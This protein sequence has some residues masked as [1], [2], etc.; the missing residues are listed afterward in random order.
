M[1]TCTK[2]K[3]EKDETEFSYSSYSSDRLQSW[4]QECNRK[5]HKKDTIQGF[6]GHLWHCFRMTLVEYELMLESQNEKCAI[7]G[8]LE[9][10]KRGKDKIRRLSVDHDHETGIIRDLLCAN[11][12]Y[13]LGN[14][15]DNPEILEEGAKY[16]RKHQK[17]LKE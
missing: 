14:A 5:Y 11:C 2:C 12:N 9:T 7:C 8:Q 15:K 16:L 10:R 1:K 6:K 17:R 4:C 3:Q 13:M